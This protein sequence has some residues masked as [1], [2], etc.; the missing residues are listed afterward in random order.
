VNVTVNNVEDAP[1]AVDDTPAAI[2]EDSGPNV[3]N[4]LSNDTDID[5]D[6]LTVSA[7]TQGSHG[8]VTNN[9]TQ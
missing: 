3:I 4:V 9:G 7:V 8:S 2:A 1:D 5:N 6:T